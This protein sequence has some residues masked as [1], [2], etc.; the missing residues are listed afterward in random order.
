ML[1]SRITVAAVTYVLMQQFLGIVPEKMHSNA[2]EFL[3]PLVT[4]PA[5]NFFELDSKPQN[6]Y[7]FENIFYLQ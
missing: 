5:P 2:S 7:P 4:V 1:P 6:R 3:K